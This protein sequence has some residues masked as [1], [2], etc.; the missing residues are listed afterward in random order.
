MAG[1]VGRLLNGLVLSKTATGALDAP[2]ARWDPSSLAFFLGARAF[3]RAAAARYN[4]YYKYYNY[5]YNVING[6]VKV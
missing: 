3:K 5:H 4:Y 6:P 1:P 2:M